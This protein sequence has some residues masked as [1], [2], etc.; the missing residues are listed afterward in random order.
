LSFKHTP[1][2]GW[3]NLSSPHEH[4]LSRMCPHFFNQKW[5]CNQ[6]WK[7]K[8]QVAIRTPLILTPLHGDR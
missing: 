3:A 8:V 4:W 2:K 7:I 6:L 1:A 5:H